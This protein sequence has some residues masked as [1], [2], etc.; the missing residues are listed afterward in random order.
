MDSIS[1]RLALDS[2][3]TRYK[4][5]LLNCG[6][7]DLK[8]STDVIVPHLTGTYNDLTDKEGENIPF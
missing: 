6:S 5:M 4:K 3:C 8:C 1:S 2:Y 7:E